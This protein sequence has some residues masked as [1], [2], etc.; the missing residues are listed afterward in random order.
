MYDTARRIAVALVAT[1][2]LA[3]S[4]SGGDADVR[5]Q[6]FSGKP[7]GV[8]KMTVRLAP[9]ERLFPDGPIQLVDPG[10]RTFYPA[11]EGID[12]NSVERD[13]A[14]PRDFTAHFLFRGSEPLSL[15]LW[16]TG[17]YRGTVRPVEN[18]ETHGKLLAAWWERYTAAADRVVQS[19]VYQPLAEDYLVATLA[20][21]LELAIPRHARSWS[22]WD[23]TNEIFSLL[24]GAE[25][26]RSAAQSKVLLETASDR[27]KADRPLPYPVGTPAVNL[28]GITADVRIEPIAMHVPEECFYVR[29]GSFANFLW[30]RSVID[31]WGTN[32][33]DLASVRG[34]D[35]RIGPRMERQ[36][37]LRQTALSRL[38]GDTVVSDVAILGTDTFLR[39]GPAIGILFE[40]R[41]STVLGMQIESRREDALEEEENATQQ[42]VQIAGRDVS[43]LATDD[44]RVR[45]FYAV[46]GKY[47][48]VT[49]SRAIVKRFLEAGQ[50]RRSLGALKEFRWARSKMP[51]SQEHAAFVYLS[52]PF[53]RL[54]IGPEYRIEMTRR[55]RAAAEIDVVRLA[56]LAAAA[57]G[58][59]ANRV[60]RL[61]ARGLLPA[62]FGHRPDGSHVVAKGSQP[63]D[64]LRGAYGSFLP[65]PDVRIAAATPSEVAAYGKF[66]RDYA[67][68]WRRMDPV[69]VGI[70]RQTLSARRERVTVDVHITPYARRHYEFAE[71]YLSRADTL[72]WTH[73][74]GDVGSLQVNFRGFSSSEVDSP[75]WKVAAGLRDYAP[76]FTIQ[77]GQV[78][79]KSPNA[80]DFPAYF[81]PSKDLPWL[82]F[83]YIY[84][85]QQTDE[86][87]NL[88][89]DGRNW[90]GYKECWARDL[91]DYY[92][93]AENTEVLAKVAPHVKL[94]DSKRPAKARLWI[95]DLAE[96]KVAAAIHA[97][98]YIRARA[99]SGG[100]VA[101]MRMLQQQ[102]RVSA[103]QTR[104][105][106]EEL[107]NARLACPLGGDYE[108]RREDSRPEW[109][110]TAWKHASLYQATSVPKDFRSPLLDWF[111][112][113]LIELDIDRDTLSTHVELDVRASHQ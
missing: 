83:G 19:D 60:K 1:L 110:S 56:R 64:S 92:L 6:A 25:S 32:L 26:V 113:V 112:G 106:A 95:G 77:R 100:N 91:G 84:A 39:E 31:G 82:P 96:T 58:K 38:L 57:E 44:N 75:G 107:L 97:E 14:E 88:R 12:V 69:V 40:A 22:Y 2:S 70:K 111:A 61:I 20:R 98:G 49:T 13:D 76:T 53:F 7:F 16:A 68:Y 11:F 90:F 47:H 35:H 37:A 78:N 72:S 66:A 23:T 18:E 65:V 99:I 17:S 48:L 86:D 104:P 4:A 36:L 55:V 103:S 27:E 59:P 105:V 109:H 5:M 8:G 52:D 74:P 21:R 71:T 81:L 43:L 87:G 24:S 102:F 15:E 63:T 33:R 73:A 41:S 62:D 9:G 89:V 42:T 93:I 85:G 34:L 94:V 10:G 67:A 101:F 50:G 80:R 79:H 28:P 30:L 108:L 54:L 46:D 3:C 51:L 29:C 45:S